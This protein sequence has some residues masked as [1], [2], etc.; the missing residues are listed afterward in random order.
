MPEEPMYNPRLSYEEN[1]E[2]GPFGYFADKSVVERAGVP[3]FSFL[4]HSV[5]LPF[6]IPAGPLLNGNFVKA[7]LDKGFDI[8]VYK[9]VRTRAYKSHAW[10]NVL[11]VQVTGDLAAGSRLV[12]GGDY[13]DPLSITNSF[14]VPSMDPDVWQ[15][16]LASCVEHAR[17]GQLVVGSYQGT[18]PEHGGGMAEYLA[19][20]RLGAR[21]MGETGVK[22][23]EVNFS[24][25]NEGTAHL[26]CFDTARSQA[27]AE[28]IRGDLG[29]RKLI[30]KIAYFTDDAALET[31]IRAI[32]PSVDAIS[33]I[34]TI[35]AEVVD[36]AGAQALP[37]AGRLMSGVCGTAIKWA[38][39]AMTR[40][41]V[42]LRETL[43]LRYEVIGVGG[44]TTS[45]DFSDYRNAGADAVMSATGAMWNPHLAEQ[46]WQAQNAEVHA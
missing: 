20:F 27:V 16:D 24:C 3:R 35:S 6:G 2:R 17:P 32:G 42:A 28:A 38:G 33:A 8:P 46:I 4:G 11:P 39:L 41:L 5:T 31:L 12:T 36:E 26:L 34:N 9:T 40:K 43:G 15:P 44:V 1:Y 37:G 18:L 22:A 30:V 7:A 25:P 19:D 29:D 45:S 10:P 23:V 21:L 13:T 14:G